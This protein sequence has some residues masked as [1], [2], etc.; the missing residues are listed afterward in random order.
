MP[1]FSYKAKDTKGNTRTGTLEA[2]DERTAAAMIREAGGLP[3]EIS[4]IRSPKSSSATNSLR[5]SA[6][7]YLIDPIWSGVNIRGLAFFYSQLH[8]LLGAGMSLSEA[9]RS[10]GGR[11]R[12]RLRAIIMEACDH[13]QRGGRFSE[14]MGKYPRVFNRLQISLMRAGESGGLLEPMIERIAAYLDY[15]LSIRRQLAKITFYPFAIFFFVILT[16]HVPLLILKGGAPFAE[17]LWGSLRVWL[18]WLLGSMVAVKYLFLLEPVRLAWDFAKIQ[19]PL[20]GT[21]ARKVAM[22]RFCRAISSLYSAGTPM[23]EALSVS[24]DACA[25]IA[26]ANGIK[27]AIGP[28]Q[29]GEKL[30]D[31]LARTGVMMPIVLDMLS[32]G[33]KTGSMDAVLAKAADYMDEEV[34][35]TIHKAGIALFVLMILIA[36][37]MVLQMV[38]AF[39]Q[40][41]F[42]GVMQRADQ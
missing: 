2:A 42:S 33:E 26:I 20:L 18:P 21:M 5:P 36:A 22:S 16:P 10:V 37:Y 11:T 15:E 12:G 17:S 8:T 28:V 25:N 6:R 9:L 29:S 13:V 38:V 24:S 3:M 4:A 35:S 31:S 30:T 19:P 41:Y 23:G 14:V 27:R 39:Y 7:S 32:T 40:S 34:D 1:T